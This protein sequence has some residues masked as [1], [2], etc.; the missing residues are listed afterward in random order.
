MDASER[1]VNAINRNEQDARREG[2]DEHLRGKIEGLREALAIV[3][4]ESRALEMLG[5]V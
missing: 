4:G 5:Q 3:A 1:I 2:M